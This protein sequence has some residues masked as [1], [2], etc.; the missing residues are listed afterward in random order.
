MIHP[1]R[2]RQLNTAPAGDGP[3]IYWMSRDMRVHD[4]WAL[5]YAKEVA[6]KKKQPF[7]I[8]Y[9]LEKNFL[10]GSRRPWEFKVAGLQSVAREC[11]KLHIPF[12]VLHEEK[13]VNALAKLIRAKNIGTVVTDFSPLRIAREWI[14]DLKERIDVAF[15][16]VDAHNVIPAWHVSDKQEYAAYTIRKKV[17]RML[18][19]FLE[20]FP[21]LGKQKR[22]WEDTFPSVDWEQIKK[23]RGVDKRALSS[24]QKAGEDAAQEQINT[25]FTQHFDGYA[26]SRNDPNK[27]ATSGISPYLHYG[28]IAPQRV[29]FD[30]H[31]Y[32][33]PENDKEAFLEELIVRRELA[34]NFCFYND[35]Y[36]SFEGFPDWAKK[37]LDAHRGDRREYTYEVDEFESASTH[38]ELWNA[39]QK[40]LLRDGTMHGYMRMYWAKKILEWTVSPEEAQAIAI[41]LNDRYQLDGRDPNGYAGIAWSIGGVHDRAWQERPIFGMI[42]YMN[43]NGCKRKFD[44]PAYIQT[45]NQQ[46]L[47]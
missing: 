37:T 46:T 47:L 10:G 34:D 30:A 4:N 43:D 16:E 22:M 11:D 1:Q 8:V 44:V 18:P 2:I 28:M 29:A 7:L 36:D 33:V 42:R 32:A 6:H 40:Q 3:V 45:H 12:T 25:F 26:D 35:H 27:D 24:E 5:L 13:N 39:A 21:Q 14:H 41:E 17:H 23:K 15:F 31:A 9:T 19:D 38:D 20:D